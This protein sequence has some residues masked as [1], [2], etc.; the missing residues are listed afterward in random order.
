MV[1]NFYV[2]LRVNKDFFAEKQTK[3]GKKR[4]IGIIRI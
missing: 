3:N 1:Q 2:S 4:H